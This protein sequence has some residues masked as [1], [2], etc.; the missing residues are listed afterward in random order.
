M[1]NKVFSST[2]IQVLTKLVTVI[3]GVIMVKLLTR[4]L[5]VEGYGLY[6]KI[7]NYASIFAIFSDLGLYTLSIRE[8]SAHR[9]DARMTR[10]IISTITTIRVLLGCVLGVLAVI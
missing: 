5:G 2:C 3:I 10:T 9:H 7:F 6:A 1:W 4:Y 8:I